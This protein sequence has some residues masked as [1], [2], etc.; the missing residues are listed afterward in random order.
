[1]AKHKRYPLYWIGRF[2]LLI[3]LKVFFRFRA[4]GS[5][6]IP[7]RS[8]GQGVILAA[9]HAS[10]LDPPILGCSVKKRHVV[11]LAKNY[12][13]QKFFL[14]WFLPRVGVYPV[15][16]ESGS[17]KSIR[18]VMRLLESG[19]CVAIFPEG[20]R[21]PDGSLRVAEDGVGF[22]AMRSRAL[23]VPVYIHGTFEAFS[24][25]AQKMR[26]VPLR[27]Y[28][29]EPFCPSE[30]PDILRALD[31]YSAIGAKIMAR[32]AGLKQH[33]F[34][35]WSQGPVS[36]PKTEDSGSN[37]SPAGRNQANPKAVPEEEQVK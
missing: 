27:T 22:I 14:N 16:G 24:R 17:L 4:H 18:E 23:V 10:Y 12:L 8:E 5:E 32:I 28:F 31:P 19:E 11:F 20:T 34:K 9:N 13:F 15:K 2:V 7:G 33:Y 1:M 25:N 21:S 26:S 35:D 30:D 29:G 3:A 6:N 37:V 36:T